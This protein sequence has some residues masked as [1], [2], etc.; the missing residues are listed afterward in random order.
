MFIKPSKTEKRSPG[1]LAWLINKAL[2]TSRFRAKVET[3]YHPR[4]KAIVRIDTV[5][6][7]KKKD[8][9][10]QHP[11]ACIA[12]PFVQ[13]KHRCGSWLEGADW[14]GFNDGLNDV[15][16]K[17]AVAADVWSFN[18][19]CKEGG[20]YF[21]RKGLERRMDYDSEYTQGAFQGFYAWVLEGEHENWC[22]KV[23]PRS[24]FPK[25]TPGYACW[26]VEQEAALTASLV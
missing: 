21:L 13:K 26:S 5:R 12:N 24:F 19:E 11:N 14:V 10:G 22:E 9:C 8:Y 23:A 6:L 4:W 17:Y 20:R 7:K 25:D 1:D 15:L 2:E 18:R 3:E 16:D